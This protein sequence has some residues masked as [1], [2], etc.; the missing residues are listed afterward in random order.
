MLTSYC[1]L[2]TDKTRAV[3]KTERNN[4]MLTIELLKESEVK[5]I[6]DPEAFNVYVNGFY[7]I[8]MTRFTA[9][10]SYWIQYEDENGYTVIDNIGYL[11]DVNSFLIGRGDS[12]V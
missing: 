5:R 2:L 1:I 7:N 10:A 11:K 6:L 3:Y 4:I 9:F 12:N 8:Y